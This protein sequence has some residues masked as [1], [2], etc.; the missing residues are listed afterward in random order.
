MSQYN[1]AS[2]KPRNRARLAKAL[3]LKARAS[4]AEIV[5]ACNEHH[6]SSSCRWPCSPMDGP[7]CQRCAARWGMP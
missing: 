4:I 2:A 6:A 7:M 3:G 5:K 1:V